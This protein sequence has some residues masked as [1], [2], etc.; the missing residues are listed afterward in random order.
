[1]SSQMPLVI[2]CTDTTSHRAV[3]RQRI[4]HTEAH[5][6]ILALGSF[7]QRTHEATPR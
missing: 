7:G 5:H 3:F 2:V 6:R 1:M 4:A